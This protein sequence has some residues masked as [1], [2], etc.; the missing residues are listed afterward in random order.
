MTDVSRE[1]D[2]DSFLDLLLSWSTRINLISPA[3]RADA[4]KRHIEDSLQLVP[5]ILQAD[6]KL[7]DLGSGGGL[8]VIP[9]AISLRSS[10]PDL[11]FTAVESDARKVAFLNTARRAFLLKNL[12]V[13][14]GRSETIAGQDADV[15]TARGFAPLDRSLPHVRRHLRPTGRAILLKGRNVEEELSRAGADWTFHCQRHPSRTD[16]TATILELRDIAHD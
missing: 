16:P 2:L 3:S 10:H 13:L 4:W 15:V 12:D 8:P 5:L 14:N 6:N 11:K 1:T 9:L 7:V